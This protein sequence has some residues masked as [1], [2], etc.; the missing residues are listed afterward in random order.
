M[1]ETVQNH[2]TEIH[3]HPPVHTW[4]GEATLQHLVCIKPRFSA[5]SREKRQKI[6]KMSQRMSLT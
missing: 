5:R 3:L 4:P 1:S 2:R 6:T